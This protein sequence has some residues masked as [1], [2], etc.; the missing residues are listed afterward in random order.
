MGY[1]EM[2]YIKWVL[3]LLVSLLQVPVD[4]SGRNSGIG[5]DSNL[6]YS[7]GLFADITADS[8]NAE[9]RHFIFNYMEE[10]DIPGCAVALIR[11]HQLA[12]SEG[13]GKMNSLTQISFSLA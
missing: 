2:R 10:Q 13:F 8:G 6:L 5:T 11:D 1:I 4:V 9:L 12:W 3:I 7:N